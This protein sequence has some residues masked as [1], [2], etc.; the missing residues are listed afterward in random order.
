MKDNRLNIVI[1]ILFLIP[2]FFAMLLQMTTIL[3]VLVIVK[4]AALTMELK[5]WIVKHI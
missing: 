2:F 3:F 1:D 5:D 4:F